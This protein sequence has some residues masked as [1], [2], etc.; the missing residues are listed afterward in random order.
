MASSPLLVLIPRAMPLGCPRNRPPTGP[1]TAHVH[2]RPSRAHA[3][4]ALVPGPDSGA[5]AVLGRPG[6]HHPA[7]LRHGGGGGH[8]SPGHH[9]ARARA[10][11]V[12]RRLRAAVAPAEG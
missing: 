8:V 4:R 7:A 10:E 9:A 5:A 12:E 2:R 3:S 6:L 11:A 1:P